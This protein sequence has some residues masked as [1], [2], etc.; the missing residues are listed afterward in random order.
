MNRLIPAIAA[1]CAAPSLSAAEPRI[2]CKFQLVPDRHVI[3]A[4]T[5]EPACRRPGAN[6]WVI[7]EAIE[8]EIEICR[9][10]PLP[11]D[12][13]VVNNT[14]QKI[15]CPRQTGSQYTALLV[16][17]PWDQELVCRSNVIDSNVF[18]VIRLE[19]VFECSEL[20][21]RDNSYYIERRSHYRRFCAGR[22]EDQGSR[23]WRV[24]YDLD[25]EGRSCAEALR[26]ELVATGARQ[27]TVIYGEYNFDQR[28]QLELACKI[29]NPTYVSATG[30]K[31]FEMATSQI[32][33]GGLD[34]CLIRPQNL[35][36]ETLQ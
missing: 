16:R 28:L 29:G 32:S 4:E 12:Y 23:Q 26:A 9:V 36:F 6:A 1:L 10:S 7:Q 17:I 21:Q 30:R 18:R 13:M 27:T 2:I 24:R 5:Y 8:P 11:P 19:S 15:E 34:G 35:P 33:R 25:T 22:V 14:L 20:G 31:T 3:V